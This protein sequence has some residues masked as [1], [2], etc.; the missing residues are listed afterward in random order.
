M[1]T[2]NAAHIQKTADA[3][4][5]ALATFAAQLPPTCEITGDA[6]Y[7]VAVTF[8]A[9]M[10]SRLSRANDDRLAR[11]RPIDQFKAAILE[12]FKAPGATIQ[13]AIDV[14]ERAIKDYRAKKRA[15][16][17]AEQRRLNQIAE[18]ERQ[19]LLKQAAAAKKPERAEVLEDRANAVVAPV[20]QMEAPKV[21]GMSA[22]Q[23]FKFRIDDPA[24]VQRQFCSPDESKIRKVVNALGKEAD[25]AGVT[26]WADEQL[27][28]RRA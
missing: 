12:L 5:K 27:S 9:D 11:T 10:K 17:E 14:H 28:T 23:V 15:E 22:R 20:V 13:K 1:T 4:A 16:A 3:A 25:I 7:E 24:L 19:R 18:A 26:I 6:S 8:L 21:S 2:L